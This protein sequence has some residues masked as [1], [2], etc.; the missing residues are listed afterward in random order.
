[1]RYRAILLDLDGTL[2]DTLEDISNAANRVLIIQGFPTHS[3]DIYRELI[4]EG[5]ARLITRI[6]PKEK[7]DAN[8]VQTCLEAYLDDYGQNWNIKTKPYVGIPEMLDAFVARGLKLAVLSNKPEE[9]T[10]KCVREL[11]SNWTFDAV[12]GTSDRIPSKPSPVG[13]LEI[14]GHLNIASE[15]FLYLGDT[16]IDMRTAIAARMFAVGVLWGFRDREEL[17]REGARV[18]IEKPLEILRLLT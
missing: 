14:A 9:F 13:A 10:Q 2:L 12:I 6:L 4:G 11:L 5:A 16:G 8:T 7:Q 1:M 3:L 15:E 18:L 17:Q